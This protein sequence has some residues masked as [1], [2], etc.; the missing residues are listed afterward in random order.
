[1]TDSLLPKPLLQV[2]HL[3]VLSHPQQGKNTPNVLL[4]PLSFT[5]YPGERLTILGETG[6]GKSLLMQAIMGLLPEGLYSQGRIF[7]A[8]QEV[9]Q[10]PAR[11]REQ[12]WGRS[13]ALLPQEPWHALD[14]LMPSYE[15]VSEVYQCVNG[16]S[17]RDSKQRAERDLQALGLKGAEDKRPDQLSGGMAQR[18]AVCAA[19]AA[20]A[21]LI[22]ADEP[23]KGLDSSRCEAIVRL[24]MDKSARGALLT[25]THDVAVAEQLGGRLLVMKAGRLQEEGQAATVLQQ[26]KSDYS[27]Q[28][29]KASPAYWPARPSHLVIQSAPKILTAQGLS[30]RRGG[31]NLFQGVD[32]DI[33]RGEIIGLAGES[34]CGKSTLGDILLGLLPPDSGRVQRLGDF[35]PQRYLKLYQ[36]PPAAFATHIPLGKLFDDVIR[37]HR[38]EAQRLWLLL[39]QLHLAPDLLKRSSHEVSGGELQRLALARI[40]LMEPVFLFAD[41]SVSRL[42]PIT[43]QRVLNLLV[44]VAQL[45]NCAVLLVSHDKEVIKKLCHR[46]LPVFA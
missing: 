4:E 32:L 5:L 2:E 12:L 37:L 1:M 34:G 31:K 33:Q 26:P 7:V 28:L 9:S 11:V 24:L 21:S 23:T 16:H 42:D 29:I 15:Q 17:L 46:S 20:G 44:D 22:L 25:I 36:D 27:R 13:I 45:Q 8:G 40:L 18:L 10:L 19:T 41:E 6:A 39:E 38:L 35:A 43:A 14:P 30:K 3:S